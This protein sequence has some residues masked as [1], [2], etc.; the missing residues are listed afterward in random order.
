ME[1]VLT[2][3]IRVINETIFY[4]IFFE[5]ICLEPQIYLALKF[6]EI[7]FCLV[8]SILSTRRSSANADGPRDATCQSKSCQLLHSSV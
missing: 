4:Y 3:I 1:N 8:K 2:A 5:N 6:N 7:P